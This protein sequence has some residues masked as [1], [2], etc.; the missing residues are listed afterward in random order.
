MP[1]SRKPS[2]IEQITSEINKSEQTALRKIIKTKV[3]DYRKAKMAADAILDD[4][5]ETLE[6][7]GQSA[8]GIADILNG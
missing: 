2:M 5:V 1:E 8:E 3:E 4:I 7:S 6:S